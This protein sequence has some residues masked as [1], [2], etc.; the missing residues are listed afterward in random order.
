MTISGR[1]TEQLDIFCRDT[2]F[3]SGFLSFIVVE[4]IRFFH[5]ALRLCFCSSGDFTMD[6]SLSE[7]SPTSV[8]DETDS[9]MEPP[10]RDI[11]A[12]VFGM[13]H[14]AAGSE[15]LEVLMDHGE[16]RRAGIGLVGR[17]FNRKY[18]RSRA[19]KIEEQVAAIDVC[20]FLLV[21]VVVI[22]G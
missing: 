21:A 2:G 8:F 10:T 6:R 12:Q 22:S 9:G 17:L 1:R 13:K 15:I 16:P 5:G 7:Q 14:I 18:R 20:R 19:S 11:E 3:T 4:L